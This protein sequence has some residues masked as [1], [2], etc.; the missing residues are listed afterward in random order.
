MLHPSSCLP[1]LQVFH[2]PLLLKT[3]GGAVHLGAQLH[4]EWASGE[5]GLN[6]TCSNSQH[7]KPC[8]DD[9]P[10]RGFQEGL[11]GSRHVLMKPSAVGL[12]AR[13]YAAAADAPH[14]VLL[15]SHCNTV[16]LFSD[17]VWQDVQRIMLLLGPTTDTGASAMSIE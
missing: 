15:P 1:L 12:T 14:P 11:S 3:P 6:D 17:A 2:Q 8:V 16:V 5:V 9:L 7:N 13:L 10:A 4:A